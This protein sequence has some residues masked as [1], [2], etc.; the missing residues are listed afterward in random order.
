M[1]GRSP[2]AVL[3]SAGPK[4][5]ELFMRFCWDMQEGQGRDRLFFPFRFDDYASETERV[6]ARASATWLS[7]RP[8]TAA[9]RVPLHGRR[10]VPARVAEDP[11]SVTM[12]VHLGVV[13]GVRARLPACPWS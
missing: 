6:A 7:Q 9:P 2:D 10:L 13:P 3:A 4:F 1:G 5:T 8:A 11:S 12:H